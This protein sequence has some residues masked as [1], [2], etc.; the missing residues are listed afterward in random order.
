MKKNKTDRLTMLTINK[1]IGSEISYDDN[2]CDFV[3][4]M[5]TDTKP[6]KMTAR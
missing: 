3:S 5:E 1:D 2:A 6:L 4:K